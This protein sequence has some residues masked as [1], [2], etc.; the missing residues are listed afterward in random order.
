MGTSTS[1]AERRPDRDE[2]AI[3]VLTLLL[4]VVLAVIV[5]A[6]ATYA[7]TTLRSSDVTNGRTESNAAASAGLDWTIEQ[8][9]EK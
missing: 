7:A 3:L 9:A 8:L 6:L 4:T 2:G 1:T 5:L